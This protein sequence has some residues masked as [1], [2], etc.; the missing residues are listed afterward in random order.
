M[1]MTWQMK[2]G[3]S[4]RLIKMAGL[5]DTMTRENWDIKMTTHV[6]IN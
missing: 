5:V 4:S 3:K 6:D 1:G 2:I